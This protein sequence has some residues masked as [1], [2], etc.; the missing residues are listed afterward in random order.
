M[1]SVWQTIENNE[2]ATNKLCHDNICEETYALTC[3][4][5]PILGQKQKV[6][7]IASSLRDLKLWLLVSCK[8]GQRSKQS[9]V[10]SSHW[11]V[12][13]ASPG[14]GKHEGGS[15]S[16]PFGVYILEWYETWN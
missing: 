10:T 4:I 3:E 15:I 11:A 1:P 13:N 9:L 7:G 14:L 8:D 6:K 5:L 12:W 2:V 16:Y